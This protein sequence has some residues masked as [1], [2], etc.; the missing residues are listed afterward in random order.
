MIGRSRKISRQ[1]WT[2]LPVPDGVIAAVEAMAA[3]EEQPI[4]GI[5]GPVFEWSQGSPS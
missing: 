5:S 1:Q 4:M 3:A 2:H